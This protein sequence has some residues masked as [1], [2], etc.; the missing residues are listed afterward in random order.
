MAILV[1]ELESFSGRHISGLRG[2]HMQNYDE[3]APL[4]TEEMR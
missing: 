4:V 3:I 2:V 1:D